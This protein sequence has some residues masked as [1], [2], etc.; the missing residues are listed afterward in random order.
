VIAQVWAVNAST[1]KPSAAMRSAVAS[2]PASGMFT[3][4]CAVSMP[5]QRGS[6][7]SGAPLV[8]ATEPC[9]SRWKVVIRLRTESS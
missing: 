1:R 6:N 8:N 3:T 2:I 9:G 7:V 5:S 4:P